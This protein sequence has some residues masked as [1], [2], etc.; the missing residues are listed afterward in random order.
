MA[1]ITFIVNLDLERRLWLDFLPNVL[2]K[3]SSI[4]H[5]RRWI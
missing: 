4:R 1:T 3:A 2:L 5:L